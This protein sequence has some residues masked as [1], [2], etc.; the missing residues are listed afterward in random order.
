MDCLIIAAGRGSRLNGLDCPKP[1]VTINKTPLIE[2]IVDNVIA[3]GVQRIFVVLGCQSEVIDAELKNINM[4]KDAHIESIYNPHWEQGNG[5][6]VL[7]AKD[8]LNAPF[9]LLMADHLFIPSM[10]KQ[11]MACPIKDNETILAVDRMI[12]RNAQVD[13]DDVTRVKIK[14]D[15][16]LNIGKHIEDYNAFDTGMFL[17]SGYLFHALE[18]S[19]EKGDSSLSG[20]MKILLEK[21]L[22]K[23]TTIK[24]ALWIDVDTPQ[25]L[26]KAKQLLDQGLLS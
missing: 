16:I 3:A 24:D 8:K 23:T 25:M 15:K 7:A 6:S 21:D 13:L 17:S 5:L 1:L 19:L 22:A 20:G 10:L 18:Q 12:V 26:D 2:Y 9:L 4:R 14:Q 11:L